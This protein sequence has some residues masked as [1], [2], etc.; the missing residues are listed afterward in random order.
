MSTVY[1]N[2]GELVTNDPTVGDGSPLGLLRDAALVVDDGVIAWVGPSGARAASAGT[3]LLYASHV[4][5]MAPGTNLGAATPVQ[6]GLRAV[7]HGEEKEPQLAEPALAVVGDVPSEP[8]PDDPLDPGT[9]RDHLI[10]RPVGEGRQQEAERA[11]EVVR[12]PHDGIDLRALH[13]CVPRSRVP[14]LDPIS[15][16]TQSQ[17]RAA[18]VRLRM[19]LRLH[20]CPMG[21]RL[22]LLEGNAA[23]P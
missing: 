1:T 5:A 7:A 19:R 4:A 10:G 17:P 13:A 20:D 23:C 2:I 15:R 12:L 14:H 18:A 9:A 22:A 11:D 16:S 21:G 8:V 3:Y 6:I